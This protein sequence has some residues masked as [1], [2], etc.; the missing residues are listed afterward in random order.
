MTG[1]AGEGKRKGEKS[2]PDFMSGCNGKMPGGRG[3]GKLLVTA[4]RRDFFR[5]GPG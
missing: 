5:S 2:N 4:P 3:V 1:G